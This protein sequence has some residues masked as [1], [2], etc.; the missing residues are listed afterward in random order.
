M[1]V[2]YFLI[3]ND[4]DFV[5]VVV[6]VARNCLYRGKNSKHN[7]KASDRFNRTIPKWKVSCKLNNSFICISLHQANC[8]L[9][10]QKKT[11]SIDSYRFFFLFI[12]NIVE[13]KAKRK[14]K[15]KIIDY[16][17]WNYRRKT[18][19]HELMI[20]LIIYSIEAWLNTVLFIDWKSLQIRVTNLNYWLNCSRS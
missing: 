8:F 4:K 9:F 1:F 11:F 18:I 5:V 16:M 15:T 12:V 6:V 13:L 19:C 2:V 20:C 14:Q 10:K 3:K 17:K 7:Q